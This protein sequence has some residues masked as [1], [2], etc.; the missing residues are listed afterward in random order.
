VDDA[1]EPCERKMREAGLPDLA[2]E[3]FRR[4]V[5]RVREGA[6]GLL[7]RDEIEPVGELPEAGALEASRPAGEEALARAVVIKLN[8]GLGTSM[9]MREAKSLL[10]V[11]GELTFL[12][13]IARQVLS[14]RR[15]HA[16]RVPLVLMNSFRTRDDSLAA[17]SRHAGIASDVPPDFLQGRVPRLDPERLVPVSWPEDPELEWCPPGHGDLYLSL[18]TSGLLDRLLERG[19][20][21]AFVSNADNLGAVLDVGILGWFASSGAPF[22]MEVTDRTDADRKGGHLARLRDGRL[23]LRESAQ[24]PDAEKDEFQD[25]ARYRYFNTNNLWLDLPALRATLDAR[26]GLLELPLIRN[27]KQVDPADPGSPR[28]LQLETAMGAALSVFP[29]ARAIRVPRV[30]FAPVKTTNDL[31]VVRSDF[32]ALHEDGRLLP[33]RPGASPPLVDLDPEHFGHVGPFRE[34]FPR[35]AP[36]LVDCCSLVVRGDVRFGADVRVRGAARVEAPEGGQERV[37]DGAVLGDAGA[38]DD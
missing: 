37:P 4:A 20:R 7:S 1:F 12:D 33:T 8:G 32:Y 26:E 34:R 35:G 3:S 14:L 27:E 18:S 21:H 29:G 6:S 30:R 10:P 24:C 16:V 28:C 38:P 23:T 25:V 2:V 36:S 19:Y 31:L 22:A 13:L 15:A 11:R 17:L 5:A 9:G